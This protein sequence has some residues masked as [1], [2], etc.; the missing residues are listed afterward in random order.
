VQVFTTLAE[1]VAEMQSEV[2]ALQTEIAAFLI[3]CKTSRRSRVMPGDKKRTPRSCLSIAGF[4]FR[5]I[6]QLLQQFDRSRPA[7]LQSITPLR[8]RQFLDLHHLPG[9]PS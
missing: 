4:L 9:I 1:Q 2:R 3:F 6:L 8:V 5:L 7:A